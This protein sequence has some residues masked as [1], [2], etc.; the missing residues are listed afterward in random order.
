MP[1][2]Y[3]LLTG[4]A[5]RERIRREDAM[6]EKEWLECADP[7]T[8]L[9]YLRARP[10]EDAGCNDAEILSHCRQPGEHVRGCCVVGLVLGM[11]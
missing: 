8:M 7:G 11:E 4:N 9:E 2:R 6:T 3:G 5:R 1:S 10:V